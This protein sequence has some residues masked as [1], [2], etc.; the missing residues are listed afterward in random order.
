MAM[1]EID[2][3]IRRAL[4]QMAEPADNEAVAASVHT[5]IRDVPVARPVQV[6]SLGHPGSAAAAAVILAFAVIVPGLV[7]NDPSP[8]AS[9]PPASSQLPTAAA[10]SIPRVAHPPPLTWTRVSIDPEAVGP[11]GMVSVAA[12][13]DGELVAGGWMLDTA[14]HH[15][16][17]TSE[18]HHLEAVIWTS[19]D[20]R[21]WQR[22]DGQPGFEHA[23]IVSVAAS[24]GVT[25]A[26]GRGAA[27]DGS[28][29]AGIWR[30][31][32][33][34]AWEQLAASGLPAD[35]DLGGL[36]PFADG[37]LVEVSTAGA[38]EIWRSTDGGSWER[39]FGGTRPHVGGHSSIPAAATPA[40]ARARGESVWLPW[41]A[42]PMEWSGIGWR[43]QR[44]RS[45][46]T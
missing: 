5:R 24:R 45:G 32:D 12:T 20:G 29:S 31:N 40:S 7:G 10:T 26:T 42:R 46:K 30:S 44:T 3:R 33:R 21:H 38:G 19:G 11:G 27:E 43:S 8:S 18:Q 14:H 39:V 35:A 22:V 1:D 17:P 28:E 2:D 6:R 34:R 36:L 4:T 37:F 41:R 23:T 15:N 25:L 13:D 9:T 16:T